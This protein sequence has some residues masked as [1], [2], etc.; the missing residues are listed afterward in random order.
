MVL[1]PGKPNSEKTTDAERL[2]QKYLDSFLE[3][4]SGTSKHNSVDSDGSS[5]FGLFELNDALPPHDFEMKRSFDRVTCCKS[6]QSLYCKE[7]LRLL[8][9]DHSLPIPVSRRKRMICNNSGLDEPY[10]E[11]RP[12]KL[13]FNLQIVLDDRRGSATGLHAV[14]L[15]NEKEGMSEKC[16]GNNNLEY[17]KSSQKDSIDQNAN[18][19]SSNDASNLGSV[20]LI[21]LGNGDKIP[22]YE[23]GDATTFLLFPSPGESIP[24]QSVAAKVQTLVVLDCKW[25]KNK[26]FFRINEELSTLQ[27]VHLSSPPQQSYYWRW[28]NAGPGMM[29]TIEAIYYASIEVSLEKQ[30]Q[31]MGLNEA[32]HVDSNEYLIDQN[33]LIHLLWL[34][35]HQ[36]A[37]TLKAAQN[38]GTPAPFSDE[39]KEHQRLLRKQKGT[40]RQLR[41]AEDERRLRERNKKK[42]EKKKREEDVARKKVQSR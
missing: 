17:Q 30:H 5:L 35:G 20:E 11:G 25:T 40:W 27:K 42:E 37:A 12:L 6:S 2:V 28:H 41:H 39:G 8:V 13:P 24:L 4:Q 3:K 15:L 18:T 34:F 23:V 9:K 38:E 32:S 31:L 10:S 1:T 16:D 29:S 22:T 21:D 36:R 14:T 7:C 26:K 19:T 33:N